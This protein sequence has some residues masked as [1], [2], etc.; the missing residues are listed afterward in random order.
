MKHFAYDLIK[1]KITEKL[2][3]ECIFNPSVLS[4]PKTFQN[5]VII[6]E[7][8][9]ALHKRDSFNIIR[10]SKVFI[11]FDIYTKDTEIEGQMYS[12]YS[13]Y[14]DIEEI[15]DKLCTDQYNLRVIT[16][17]P[18]PNLDRDV[19]KHT[20]IYECTQIDTKGYFF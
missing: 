3:D 4:Y 18:T 14:R 16:S 9:N 11:Q 17:K 12:R 7:K 1:K 10:E 13:V 2:T 20:I 19:Y 6:T 15:I 8:D 5:E